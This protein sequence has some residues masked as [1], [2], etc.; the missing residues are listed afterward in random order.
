MTYVVKY[1]KSNYIESYSDNRFGGRNLSIFT[2][3]HSTLICQCCYVLT[4]KGRQKNRK[5]F[6][7]A[8]LFLE[9]FLNSDISE[10]ADL[11]ISCRGQ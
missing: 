4:L 6:S 1:L 3:V 9:L 7:D 11:L 10:L 5:R 8:K 2:M